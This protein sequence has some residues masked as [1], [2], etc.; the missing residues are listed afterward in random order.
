MNI[1]TILPHARLVWTIIAAVGLA[2]CRSQAEP[3]VEENPS[4]RPQATELE[5]DKP[6]KIEKIEVAST[7][8]AEGKPIPKKFTGEGE[9]VSPPLA[10]QGVPEGTEQLALICDDPDA[11]T[12]E[13]SEEHTSELQSHSIILYAVFCL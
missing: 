9:D 1:R 6:M 11:P 5:G 13:R 10:F 3:P 8:F 4:S 7:A 2:G 12:P